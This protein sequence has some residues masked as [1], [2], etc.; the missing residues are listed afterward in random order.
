MD[1]SAPSFP[2]GTWVFGVGRELV[3]AGA[4]K[5]LVMLKLFTNELDAKEFV[6]QIGKQDA[7]LFKTPAFSQTLQYIGVVGC[8]YV[9]VPLRAPESRILR[10]MPSLVVPS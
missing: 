5:T 8:S 1:K 6:E 2:E 7:E 3:Y 9:V 4:V 10:A